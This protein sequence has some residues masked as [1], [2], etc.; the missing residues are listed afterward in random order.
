MI[1]EIKDAGDG[2]DLILHLDDG[3]AVVVYMNDKA[4]QDMIDII[5][6]KLNAREQ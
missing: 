2:V 4:A 5:Q 3:L 1:P 6:N